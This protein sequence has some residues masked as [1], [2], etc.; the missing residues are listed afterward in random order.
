MRARRA[1]NP[2][3]S[4]QS[5]IGTSLFA[6]IQSH[7]ETFYST[8]VSAQGAA[9]SSHEEMVRLLHSIDRFF[10]ARTNDDHD[11][12]AIAGIVRI[13]YAVLVLFDR[14]L[15]TL[16]FDFFFLSSAMPLSVSS[17]AYMTS[18]SLLWLAPEHSIFYWSVHALT[19]ILAVLLL[20]V[21]PRLSLVGLLITMSAFWT[22]N[23]RIWDS[24]DNIFRLWAIY[25]LFL[26]IEE[27]YT[28]WDRF[29]TT[30]KTT[31]SR[32]SWPMW[33]FRIWQFQLMAIYTS[34][35]LAKLAVPEWQ[36]GS[37][38][39]HV[40]FVLL[41]VVGCRFQWVFRNFRCWK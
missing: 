37:A 38:M 31:S 36:N 8:Q 10:H 25:L 18:T 21:L 24:Q 16:D 20:G 32:T 30:T 22:H 41:F 2:T 23:D 13:A 6:K 40:R 29:G 15:L 28:I 7:D 39:L 1:S 26:P 34:A 19:I 3:T 9:S 14:F 4:R 35:G 12:L 11:A 27:R 17:R 33:P 5:G